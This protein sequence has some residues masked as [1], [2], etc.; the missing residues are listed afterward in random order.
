M[1]RGME[2]IPAVFV[3]GSTVTKIK[4]SVQK[5]QPP[6]V[7]SSARSPTNRI[8][9]RLPPSQVGYST[10]SGT[11]SSGAVVGLGLFCPLS[12]TGVSSGWT[13]SP[14]QLAEGTPGSDVSRQQTVNARAKKK[15]PTPMTNAVPQKPIRRIDNCGKRTLGI[16]VLIKKTR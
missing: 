9:I 8:L 16:L 13:V 4:V 1:S 3:I 12:I 7:G 6:S 14:A 5:G 2:S 15:S 11:G 10:S